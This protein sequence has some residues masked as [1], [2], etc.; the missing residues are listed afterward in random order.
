[1]IANSTNISNRMFRS[2]RIIILSILAAFLV[3]LGITSLS[4]HHQVVVNS[5]KSMS[6]KASDSIS[7]FYNK[8]DSS[9]SSDEKLIEEGKADAEKL[10]ELADEKLKEIKEEE[11]SNPQQ[12]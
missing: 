6:N 2:Q 4:G 7:E 3:L 10:A 12:K 5:V 9:L 1:M 8:V 11:N